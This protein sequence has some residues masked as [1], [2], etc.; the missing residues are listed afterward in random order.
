M[1]HSLIGSFMSNVAGFT[2]AKMPAWQRNETLTAVQYKGRTYLLWSFGDP[3]K[4]VGR[5]LASLLRKDTHGGQKT[6][7][8]DDG[9]EEQEQ[10]GG[11]GC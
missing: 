7:L 2:P 5:H 4:K 11:S 1:I 10:D 6:V 8:G 3:S 9:G